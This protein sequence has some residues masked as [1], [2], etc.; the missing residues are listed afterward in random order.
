MN[1]LLTHLVQASEHVRK[2]HHRFTMLVDLMKYVVAEKFNYIAISC[3]GPARRAAKSAWSSGINLERKSGDL[4]WSL[5]DE[6]KL[7]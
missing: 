6:A 2:V 5:V 1:Y 4:L 7:A 3:F